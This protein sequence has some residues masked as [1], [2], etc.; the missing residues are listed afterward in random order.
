MYRD[1]SELRRRR[2]ALASAMAIGIS[3]DICTP[4]GWI[5]VIYLHMCIWGKELAS[6]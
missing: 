3:I 4:R 1:L 2:R 5:I 6:V